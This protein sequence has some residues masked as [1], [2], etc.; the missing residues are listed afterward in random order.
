MFTSTLLDSILS[1][2][3]DS[4]EQK[5]NKECTDEYIIYD[6]SGVPYSD[7]SGSI[8]N[9]NNKQFQELIETLNKTIID[10]QKQVLDASKRVEKVHET[11]IR[12]MAT[13]TNIDEE[14]MNRLR[15]NSENI[16]ETAKNKAKREAE[17]I[18]RKAQEDANK[19]INN[20]MNKC[21][22]NISKKITDISL[23]RIKKDATMELKLNNVN[24]IL[25]ELK[26]SLHN[27]K[28]DTKLIQNQVEDHATKICKTNINRIDIE[29]A[30]IKGNQLQ[31]PKKNNIEKDRKNLDDVIDSE[32]KNLDK[33]IK[34]TNEEI[35]EEEIDEEEIDGKEIKCKG[36]CNNPININ[37]FNPHVTDPTLVYQKK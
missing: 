23:E 28:Q 18:K 8:N 7:S 13:Q 9:P 37:H 27:A 4:S 26:N 35:D 29:T 34:D 12:Q 21:K 5:C 33:I 11:L 30:L 32:I 25:Q 24:N 2:K 15:T 19:V 1:N 17:E 31:D 6:E 36:A 14:I 22:T 16:I 20:A 3:K 10:N